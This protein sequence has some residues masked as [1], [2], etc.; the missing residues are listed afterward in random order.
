MRRAGAKYRKRGWVRWA[1][2]SAVCVGLLALAHTAIGQEDGKA[3]RTVESTKKDRSFEKAAITF[4][5][6]ANAFRL[7]AA[8]N[9]DKAIEVFGSEKFKAKWALDGAKR[10]KTKAEK[11]ILRDTFAGSAV[12]M[13]RV[14]LDR[15]VAC[16]YS[17]WM[18]AV[19]L[20]GLV[21]GKDGM[22]RADDYR[23]VAGESW[24]NEQDVTAEKIVSLYEIKEPLIMALIAR[25]SK[26]AAVFDKHYP[27]RGKYQLVPDDLKE[28]I[29]ST[30]DAMVP[31]VA[32]RV[33]RLHMYQNYGTKPNANLVQSVK[34]LSKEVK[35]GDEAKLKAYLNGKQNAKMLQAVCRLPAEMRADLK[36]MYFAQSKEKAVV[37][38]VNPASPRWVIV[39]ELI[40]SATARNAQLDLL[41]LNAS[42]KLVSIAKGGAE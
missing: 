21:R 22:A 11:N 1:T 26:T 33:C 35:D 13:G 36:P 16:F 8:G 5:G 15:A 4:I 30:A 14:E 24:R 3:V 37:A 32:R 23:L 7:L 38:L 9:L 12:M 28:R 42:A 6:H 29:G 19:V 18:D 39:A 40:K 20:L 2:V 34:A 17:P 25:Y 10:F 27:L 41:D 31:M